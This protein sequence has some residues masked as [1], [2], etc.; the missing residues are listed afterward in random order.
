VR[1]IVADRRLTPVSSGALIQRLIEIETYRVLALLG[2]PM[3]QKLAP[4][5]RRIEMALPELLRSM[6]KTQG[7]DANR[8][9]LDKLTVFATEIES[10]AAESLYRFG[11]TRAY[12]EL[13]SL[14]LQAIKE[15]PVPHH[16]TLSSFL[17]R[18]FQPALRTCTSLENR[19]ALLSTKIARIAELLRTR[20]D[21]EMESQN[22]EELRQMAER[23]RLQ[24]RLQQ[25]VEGLS[26]AAITYYVSSVAYLIFDG[27]H[28]WGLPIS[29]AVWTAAAVPFVFLAVTLVVW[30]IRHANRHI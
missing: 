19:Q 12:G 21:I 10:G 2:L 11:A 5:V 17:A 26:V 15:T 4:S 20:V 16:S 6:G 29:P 22:I 7:L 30:R 14:R 9:M 23:Q 18:R 13:V 25:T 1:M 8:T 28:E 24:L 27:L 3:A